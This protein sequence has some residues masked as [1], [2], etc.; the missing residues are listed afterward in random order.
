MTRIFLHL[1]GRWYEARSSRALRL[2]HQFK[3]RAE[4]F[5][6]RLRRKT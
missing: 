5:F 6:R 3:E 4:E 1:M 2:H